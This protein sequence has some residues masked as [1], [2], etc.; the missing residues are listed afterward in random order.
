MEVALRG[1][2]L[3]EHVAQRAA[4]TRG[5][6]RQHG[7]G[8]RAGTRT[9]LDDREHRGPARVVPPCVEGPGDHHAEQRTHLG[10]GEEV[11]APAGAST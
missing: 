2:P 7:A 5:A 8:Q 6:G 10:A 1:R 11:T 4:R 9:G 3:D